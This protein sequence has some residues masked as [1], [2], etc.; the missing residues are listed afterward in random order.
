MNRTPPV[1][2]PFTPPAKP[3]DAYLDIASG[4]G[5]VVTDRHGNNYIDAMASLWFANLGYNR[6]EVIEA[7]HEQLGRIH[8]YHLFDPFTNGP[9]EELAA[10]LVELAPIDDGRVFFGT[11]GSDAVDTALKLARAAHL[12][13]GRPQKRLVVSRT[14]GYH[15][16]NYGGT[17]S[18]GIEANREG[19]GELVPHHVAVP[20]DD[21]EALATLFAERG[22]EIAA[23]LTE[24]LQGAGGVLP[25]PAGYLE[26]V[27]RLCTDHDAYFICDEVICGFGRLG[28]WFGADF[29]GVRPDMITFAKAVTSGY[30]PLGGVIVGDTVRA[31]LEADP[32]YVLRTGYTYSGHAAACA[33][34]I[35]CLDVT[36]GD[37][38]LHAATRLGGRLRDGLQALVDDGLYAGLRGEG[39]VY[40]LTMPDHQS[41]PEQRNRLR[42]RGVI[43][44]P[45]GDA[46]AFCPPLVIT[47][48]QIDQVVD[49]VAAIA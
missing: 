47:D 34:G 33:A 39:F 11:S 49:A 4:Q 27:R 1:L 16:T 26:G 23:V 45:L 3:A 30:I 36:E 48:D 44:R 18:Q 5:A 6:R 14:A 2:H 8:A 9:A 20:H 10:R 29:Y 25:P 46:L 32:D 35:A 19:F 12:R 21:L 7:I 37:G 42:E 22:D 41:A 13:A 38:L 28:R 17:S 31:P 40:A 15:G 43:A 24:P